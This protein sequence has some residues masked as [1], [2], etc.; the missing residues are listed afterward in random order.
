MTRKN[1]DPPPTE[2]YGETVH[3]SRPM[4]DLMRAWKVPNHMR[5]VVEEAFE[6]GRRETMQ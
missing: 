5:K 2:R 3:I 4:A 1:Q 6:E